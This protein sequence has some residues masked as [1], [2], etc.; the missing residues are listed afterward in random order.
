MRVRSMLTGHP[1][2]RQDWLKRSRWESGLP[3]PV[4][5]RHALNSSGTAHG[6]LGREAEQGCD[7][8]RLGQALPHESDVEQ[9][10]LG[11]PGPGGCVQ[12]GAERGEAAPQ[13]LLL[14]VEQLED[15]E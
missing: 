9:H 13:I 4:L 5:A 7:V 2:K 6:V 12:V 1:Q 11:P 15:L 3:L 14:E 8:D 10:W